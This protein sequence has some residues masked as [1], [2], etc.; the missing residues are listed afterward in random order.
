MKKFLAICLVL[1]MASVATASLQISVNGEPEPVDSEYILGPSDH[2]TLDI[3]TDSLIYGGALGEG[4]WLLFCDTTLA[5]ISG[6]VA[7]PAITAT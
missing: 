6:G 5:T 3:Y 1:G 4:D 7:N 2:L